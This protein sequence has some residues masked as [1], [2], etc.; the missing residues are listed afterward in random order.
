MGLRSMRQYTAGAV[1]V[2]HFVRGVCRSARWESVISFSRAVRYW[3]H[4][5]DNAPICCFVGITHHAHIPT[6]CTFAKCV[7]RL[8]S[9]YMMSC[10]CLCAHL[11]C[12]CTTTQCALV[13]PRDQ[14][15]G[16]KPFPPI[17]TFQPRAFPKFGDFLRRLTS[18]ANGDAAHGQ[19]AMPGARV[20][21]LVALFAASPRPR[22]THKVKEDGCPVGIAMPQIESFF[23]APAHAPLVPLG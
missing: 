17:A 11:A 4:W 15:R 20:T 21:S 14:W 2:R 3:Y 5:F 8:Y 6:L 19:S 22:A 13:T 10:V 1:P 16:S 9:T 23:D 7:L 12:R 18:I